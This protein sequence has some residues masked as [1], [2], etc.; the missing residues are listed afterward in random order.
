MTMTPDQQEALR[1]QAHGDGA[2]AAALA[3]RD[4]DELAR[5][6]SIGRTRQ[7]PREIGNG[8]IIETL[9]IEAGN[10]LLDHIAS[11][12]D[13]RHVRPLLEQGRLIVGAPL[14][15]AA[16]QSYVQLPDVITQADADALCALGREPHALSPQDVADALYNPDGTLK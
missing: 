15:Q 3:A 4:I 16:L 11:D 8:T 12:T 7:S 1:A 10:K 6:L 13:L 5:I 9:G 14:V 2:C